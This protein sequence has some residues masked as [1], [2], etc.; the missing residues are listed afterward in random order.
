MSLLDTIS[1]NVS[2]STTDQEDSKV[3]EVKEEEEAVSDGKKPGN[4]RGKPD[5]IGS[6][7]DEIFSRSFTR[8]TAQQ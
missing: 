7:C 8:A 3:T 4:N 2:E 1:A 6:T 5:G